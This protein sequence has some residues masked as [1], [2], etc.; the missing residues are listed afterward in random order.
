G[1]KP[2]EFLSQS[3]DSLVRQRGCRSSRPAG[4]TYWR[5]AASERYRRGVTPKR[6]LKVLVKC[7]GSLKP[8]SRAMRVMVCL[9]HRGSQSAS[10]HR[11]R[12]R[13]RANLPADVLL[14]RITACRWLVEIWSAPAISAGV[15]SG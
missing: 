3:M 14:E 6:A 11:S 10:R 2:E 4:Q 5:D 8:Q 15:R 13:P 9:A 1:I 12:R 7:A